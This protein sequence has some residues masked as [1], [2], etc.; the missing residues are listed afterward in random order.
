[1]AKNEF[2]SDFDYEKEYGPLTVALPAILEA[3]YT[4]SEEN[5]DHDIFSAG[6]VCPERTL[7]C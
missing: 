2:D 3:N 4:V 5:P 7:A 1:M 6:S